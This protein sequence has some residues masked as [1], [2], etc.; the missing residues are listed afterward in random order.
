MLRPADMETWLGPAGRYADP[1][2]QHSPRH[3][4]GFIRD[5]AKV[6]SVGFVE[7][8]VVHVGLFFFVQEVGAERFIIDARASNRHF[9][10]PPSGPLLTGEGVCHVEFLQPPEDARNWFVGSADIKLHFPTSEV[11]Y[12]GKT[13]NQNFLLPT[14]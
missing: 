1:V 10:R 2:F 7:T 11:G 3:Y 8:A 9:L 6:G 12:T 5:L 14:L 4:L 13:V